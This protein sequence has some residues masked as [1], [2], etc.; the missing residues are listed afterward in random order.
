MSDVASV[1]STTMSHRLQKH[2][3][4][5]WSNVTAPQI[6]SSLPSLSTPDSGHHYKQFLRRT[7]APMWKWLA[8]VVQGVI[9]TI[10]RQADPLTQKEQIQLFTIR[11]QEALRTD[12]SYNQQNFGNGYKT[13]PRL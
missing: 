9:L 13:R 6:G 4:T 8:V 12:I 2:G 11:L 10:L 1:V 5:I 3:T 7:G